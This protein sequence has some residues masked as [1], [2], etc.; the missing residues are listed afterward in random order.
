MATYN[1]WTEVREYRVWM[2]EDV[3][4][5]VSVARHRNGWFHVYEDGS[6]EELKTR[7][8]SQAFRYALSRMH[9]LETEACGTCPCEDDEDCADAARNVYGSPHGVRSQVVD[10]DSSRE[11]ESWNL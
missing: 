1:G 6:E 3:Y 4:A 2:A 9:V 8:E 5:V 10:S 7:Q 11:I